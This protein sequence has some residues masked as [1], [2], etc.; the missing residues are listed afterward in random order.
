MIVMARFSRPVALGSLLLLV[1]ASR[2]GDGAPKP[3]APGSAAPP[4]AIKAWLK[5]DRMAGLPKKGICVVEFWATWCGPC[6]ESIPHVTQMAKANPDVT[7]LGVGVWEPW[8]A[9]K[10]PK[11]VADRGDKMDYRVAYSGD[12]DGMAA[13]WLKPGMQDGI[14]CAF[15]IKDGR[16]QWIGHPDLLEKP[17]A[18]VKAGTFDLN[19]ARV[20][21]DG[22]VAKVQR[23]RDALDALT[24]A[25]ELYVSG[26]REEGRKALDAAVAKYP[27]NADT[28][29]RQR[30]SWL[31]DEDP[32]AWEVRARELAATKDPKNLAILNSFALRRA[33]VPKDVPL[34]RTALA[35]ALDATDW[36]EPNTL[37]YGTTIY[38]Q[39]KDDALELRATNALL[40]NWPAK[41]W[42]DAEAVREKLKKRKVEL[43]AKAGSR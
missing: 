11:F 31:A 6:I 38:A 9:V 22:R 12:Q 39:L 41:G 14:P 23:R 36:K 24:A 42:E 13:S 3:L 5:G 17:L 8:D 26:K 28:A 19:A 21:F 40:D 2:A 18:Q 10:L 7:F 32:K 25:V 34:A 37:T 33:A 1:A 29:D 20:A 43:E 27:E 4:L 35:L 30:F 15:L 16:I